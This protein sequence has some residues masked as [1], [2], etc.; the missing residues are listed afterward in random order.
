MDVSLKVDKYV[1]FLEGRTTRES[2][3][4]NTYHSKYSNL[5]A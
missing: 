1:W 2:D 5:G 4:L 3:F